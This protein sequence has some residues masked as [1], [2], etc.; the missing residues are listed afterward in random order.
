MTRSDR[1]HLP[2]EEGA[3]MNINEHKAHYGH[4]GSTRFEHESNA[5]TATL[6]A[7]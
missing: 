4:A 7:Q 6:T 2:A 1:G 5:P 3:C